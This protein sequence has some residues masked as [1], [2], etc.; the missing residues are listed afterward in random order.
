MVRLRY[1]QINWAN[2]INNTSTRPDPGKAY[3]QPVLINIPGIQTR[4]GGY[5]QGWSF[6]IR[7]PS[8]VSQHYG[9]AAST[10]KQPPNGGWVS[11]ENVPSHL[12]AA[13]LVHNEF[14]RNTLPLRIAINLLFIE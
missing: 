9:G 7:S 2:N 6:S 3:A 11:L 8:R 5:Y 12:H 13:L 14:L 10:T 4:T 1:Q